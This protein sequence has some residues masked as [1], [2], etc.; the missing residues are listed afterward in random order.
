MRLQRSPHR[1]EASSA[2][3]KI[4]EING[5]WDRASR[6]PRAPTHPTLGHHSSVPVSIACPILSATFCGANRNRWRNTRPSSPRG[7]RRNPIASARPCH[8]PRLRCEQMQRL[9]YGATAPRGSQST[10]QRRRLPFSPQS[11]LVWSSRIK[12]K[13]GGLL[14][15]SLPLGVFSKTPTARPK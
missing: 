8:E 6:T 9:I 10:R 14:R 2:R 11:P 13:H 4:L 3:I 5:K 1:R 12:L 15:A 7:P